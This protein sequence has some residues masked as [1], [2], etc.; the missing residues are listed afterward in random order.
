MYLLTCGFLTCQ[1]VAKTSGLK[2]TIFIL[3]K[4][5]PRAGLGRSN[6]PLLY[7]VPTQGTLKAG[8]GAT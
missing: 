7:S 6:S 2:T 8:V 3:L 1:I 4:N 5:P